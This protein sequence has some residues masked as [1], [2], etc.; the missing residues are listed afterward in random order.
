MPHSVVSCLNQLKSMV[1]PWDPKENT[2]FVFCGFSFISHKYPDQEEAIFSI[3]YYLI[4][5]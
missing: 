4:Y 5:G 3:C 2:Y 1:V